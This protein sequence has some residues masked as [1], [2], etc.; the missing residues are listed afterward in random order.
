MPKYKNITTFTR[1]IT[2]SGKRLIIKPNEILFS[3]RDLDINI[4]NFLEKVDDKIE[5]SKIKELPSK[6]ITLPKPQEITKLK[7]DIAD[8]EKDVSVLKTVP[9]S[10]EDLNAQIQVAFKRLESMKNAVEEVNK[11]AEEALTTAKQTDQAVKDLSIEVYENGGI[12]ITDADEE[13]TKG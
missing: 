2:I 8:V 1:P 11:I 3:E 5:A 9:K 4:Y 10:I 6:K 13:T 12:I 7:T